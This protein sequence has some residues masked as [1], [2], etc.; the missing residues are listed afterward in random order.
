[1]TWLAATY[2]VF[3]WI[4]KSEYFFRKH[5]QMQNISWLPS[6]EKKSF[7]SEALAERKSENKD[8]KI[9][10]YFCFPLKSDLTFRELFSRIEKR[11]RKIL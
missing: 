11:K 1:M 8:D 4:K 3:F 5:K 7:L 10:C 6:V 9:L 2:D